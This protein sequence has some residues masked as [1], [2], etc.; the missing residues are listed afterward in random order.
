[1]FLGLKLRAGAVALSAIAGLLPVFAADHAVAMPLADGGASSATPV[2][3]TT[4][5]T[6][7][8]AAYRESLLNKQSNAIAIRNATIEA[9]HAE[10]VAELGYEPGTTDPR[11]I[12][13]QI[14]LN[15]YSWGE[16]E[17]TCYDDIIMRESKWI[18]TADNPH[19]T[20]YGIPQALPGKRMAAFGDD[21]LTNPATQIR[22]A[23]TT[24]TTATA[25]P[26][27][28]GPSSAPTAGTEPS[29][30]KTGL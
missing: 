26:A 9:I 5:D 14:M 11:E 28:P 17:F 6:S 3:K 13:R 23:S 2:A 10:T 15:K 8:L 18:V 1:V 30:R 27:K 7:E 20:A 21:W 25:P 16:D 24:S 22:W 12:A 19:S 4:M 29:H